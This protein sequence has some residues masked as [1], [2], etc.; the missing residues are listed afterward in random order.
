MKVNIVVYV[1]NY[2]YS[3][4]RN[5]KFNNMIITSRPLAILTNPDIDLILTKH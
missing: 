2:Y 5:N 3:T 1:N 4:S